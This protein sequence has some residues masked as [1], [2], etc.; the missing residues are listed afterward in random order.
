MDLFICLIAWSLTTLIRQRSSCWQSCNGLIMMR[1]GWFIKLCRGL[2]SIFTTVDPA[3]KTKLYH[4]G[5]GNILMN[6]SHAAALYVVHRGEASL[7]S[8]RYSMM[9]WSHIDQAWRLWVEHISKETWGVA[10]NSSSDPNVTVISDAGSDSW[11]L[12]ANTW[13]KE[14]LVIISLIYLV[15]GMRINLFDQRS[16]PHLW[17]DVLIRIQNRVNNYRCSLT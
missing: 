6:C 1:L 9:F 3:I 10:A 7:I 17:F 15:I 5:I 8:I 12:K 4:A 14:N 16:V 13:D 11:W 2:L